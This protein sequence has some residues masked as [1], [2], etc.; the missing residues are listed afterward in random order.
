MV[1]IHILSV[2]RYETSYLYCVVL[3]GILFP[4]SRTAEQMKTHR[5]AHF[6]FCSF[7]TCDY[8]ME[9]IEITHFSALGFSFEYRQI[10]AVWLAKCDDTYTIFCII[11]SFCVCVCY[12]LMLFAFFIFCNRRIHFVL[13][14][15]TLSFWAFP[16]L[17]HLM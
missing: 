17:L 12:N 11:L 6:L 7:K 8:A 16:L 3:V 4:S 5:T 2:T 15:W 1:F 13:P 14:V 10:E 9:S